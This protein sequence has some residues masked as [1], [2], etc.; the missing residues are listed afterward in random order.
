M[1]MRCDGGVVLAESEAVS[2]VDAVSCAV[3]DVQSPHTLFCVCFVRVLDCKRWNNRFARRANTDSQRLP[4]LDTLCRNV[5][6]E[7]TSLIKAID[8]YRRRLE[9]LD[10]ER[11]V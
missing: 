5:I 11:D 10:E 8:V 2:G 9:I 7:Y 4:M 6:K 3:N 1:K